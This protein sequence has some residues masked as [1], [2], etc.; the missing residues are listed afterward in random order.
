MAE[1]LA[2]LFQ[3]TRSPN[4]DN[5]LLEQAS[6]TLLQAYQD[7]MTINVLFEIFSNYQNPA[8]KNAVAL[9][10]KSTILNT[11]QE[12][13]IQNE[14]L[15]E[16]VKD[17]FLQ[18]L[19]KEKDHTVRRCLFEAMDP[20]FMT[21]LGEWAPFIQFISSL[22]KE[23][24]DFFTVLSLSFQY[25]PIQAVGELFIPIFQLVESVFKSKTPNPSIISAGASFMTV[26]FTYMSAEP[27]AMVPLF[28]ALTTCLTNTISKSPKYLTDIIKAITE[29]ITRAPPFCDA[30][31]LVV[32][33][34]T[35]AQNE[36]IPIDPRVLLMD[37]INAAFTRYFP[38]LMEL[39][40]DVIQ[41]AIT[42]GAQSFI[43]SCFDSQTNAFIAMEIMETFVDMM[44]PNQF[45]EE[46][47]SKMDTDSQEFLASFA[48]GLVLFLEHIPEVAALH[49]KDIA[50]FSLNLMQADH[51]CLQEAGIDVL[52]EIVSRVSEPISDLSDEILQRAIEILS[53]EENH[54]EQLLNKALSFLTEYLCVVPVSSDNLQPLFEAICALATSL[55]SAFS[56]LA[57]YAL[58]NLIEAAGTE[59]P[60][61]VEGVLPIIMEAAQSDDDGNSLL[62][63]SGIEA[64]GVL[65][66]NA[67]QATQEI[68]SDAIQLFNEACLQD[69]D[70]SLFTSST[71][72]ITNL[73]AAK[74]S[75]VDAILAGVLQKCL[76]IMNNEKDDIASR[77]LDSE[78]TEARNS[79]CNFVTQIFKTMPDACSD[80][81]PQMMVITSRL[82]DDDGVEKAALKA[83]V[84]I[85]ALT[86]EFPEILVTHLI[87]AFDSSNIHSVTNCFYG[88]EKLIKKGI[89]T[90]AA[91]NEQGLDETIATVIRN[92]FI[93]FDREL[94]CQQKNGEDAA[95]RPVEEED[96]EEAG[97]P[98]ET[99]DD[100][101][102]KDSVFC[103][104]AA[105]AQYRP[106]EF[107][108][109]DFWNITNTMIQ[110]ERVEERIE[111]IGVLTEYYAVYFANIPEDLRTAMEQA[112]YE[113]L[114][115]VDFSLPSFP[116]AAIRCVFEINGP[117]QVQH[118]PIV[119]Q[120]I[121][122]LLETENEGQVYYWLTIAATVSL[123][124][125]L[126]KMSPGD[127]DVDTYLPKMLELAPR[128][129][130]DTESENIIST[131][132]AMNSSLQ[133]LIAQ[134]AELGEALVAV[135]RAALDRGVKKGI[136][137]AT[138][139]AAAAILNSMK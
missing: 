127:F 33:L 23:P 50:T 51:H 3:I 27:E 77:D 40:P 115:L 126:F 122:T 120:V 116:I 106:Q 57:I 41:L 139:T 18:L 96:D 110:A 7:P 63:G 13:I 42:L 75:E 24:Q 80:I 61:Y 10:M 39:V 69:D 104:F 81:I 84:Q 113:S 8:D 59:M 125:T 1:E 70:I 136:K 35:L 85:A 36:S 31:Q 60:N 134:N 111:C 32:P 76:N 130:V 128:C 107:P 14:E 105:L 137:E 118:L 90:C 129:L 95:P 66:K 22:Q 83:A 112:F 54:H 67:P 16:H 12:Q 89:P 79:A 72:A 100:M 48:A 119:Y 138:A 91:R 55:D 44:D 124:F 132:V 123:L 71:M 117:A 97:L 5:E 65:I 29:I 99:E 4:P 109:E 86:K 37:P 26:M 121:N 56:Y 17:Q 15:K 46:Y 38:M 47:W 74:I 52:Y 6:Q 131:L 102:L 108:L 9:G 11:W 101:D 45:F 114:E 88:F 133:P 20:I 94:L 30:D 28:E 25:L 68:H 19:V 53:D 49:F 43:D 62:M 92:G 98:E 34:M 78:M 87:E 93:W 2:S 73:V 82:I 58:S 21:E 64:L 135:Y 103:F